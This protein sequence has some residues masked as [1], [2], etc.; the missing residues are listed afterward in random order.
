M[1]ETV[2]ITEGRP[3]AKTKAWVV[4]R[5]VESSKGI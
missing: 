2:E 4:T 5:L 1:G 3:I